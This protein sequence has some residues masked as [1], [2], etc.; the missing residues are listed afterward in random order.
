MTPELRKEK[1]A[2][3][4]LCFQEA[5]DAISRGDA[6]VARIRNNQLSGMMS[7]FRGLDSDLYWLCV[8]YSGHYY[9]FIRQ[10]DTRDYNAWAVGQACKALRA[11]A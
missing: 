4:R 3:I 7:A 10:Q 2:M 6:S 5:V 9:A 1:E 11:A 8:R